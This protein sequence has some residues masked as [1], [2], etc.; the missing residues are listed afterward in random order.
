MRIPES[1]ECKES[2]LNEKERIIMSETLHK[3]TRD[4]IDLIK[5]E[6]KAGV[7]AALNGKLNFDSLQIELN[8]FKNRYYAAIALDDLQ[9]GE[10]S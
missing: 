3:E 8:L 1:E 10:L 4:L 9:K 6:F 5:A 2:F 7:N